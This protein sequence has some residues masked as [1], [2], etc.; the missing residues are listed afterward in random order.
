MNSIPAELTGQFDFCWSAC[1][2]EHL[3]SI[4]NGLR[5]IER[6]VECLVPGGVAVHT[7]E[8]N[9][10]SDRDTLDHAGTVLFRKRDFLNLANRLAAKG[11][12]LRLSF[13]LGDLPL[14]K[15]VDVAP[16][17]PDDHLKLQLDR[18]VTTSFGLIIHKQ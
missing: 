17:S 6:S 8:F 3:G 15:H 18:W 4:K 11:A 16:Y 10:Y 7:T 2:L 13:D 1:A 5:F 14:D 12:Q 9:C